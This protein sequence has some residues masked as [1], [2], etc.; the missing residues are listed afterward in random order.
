MCV[1]VN[2]VCL[3][4]NV[5]KLLE[6]IFILLIVSFLFYEKFNKRGIV[7]IFLLILFI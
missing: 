3:K 4:V 7:I 6:Y 1:G 5:R 2:F